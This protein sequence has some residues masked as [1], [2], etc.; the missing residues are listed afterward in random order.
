MEDQINYPRFWQKEYNAT[1][2]GKFAKV[3]GLKIVGIIP[4]RGGSKGIPGKNLTE[5]CGRPLLSWSIGQALRSNCVNEVY[6]SSDSEEILEAAGRFGASPITRPA[7]LATDEASSEAAL[8]HALSHIEQQAGPPD[9]VLFLQCT[10][11]LRL[12]QDI[13]RAVQAL[14]RGNA[15]SLLSV[16]P[17]QGV[18]QWE[19]GSQGWASVNYDYRQR[20][21]RQDSRRLFQENGSIYLFKPHILQKH[22]NRLGGVITVLEMAPWQAHEIDEWED[23]ALCQH[24]MRRYG[25]DRLGAPFLGEVD[26]VAYDFDGVMTDNRVLVDEQGREY[27]FCNRG[28][29]WAVDA[30]RAKG[31][32]QL[33]ITSE[34][35]PVVQ[36]RAAKL[37]IGVLSSVK[38]KPEALREWCRGKGIDLG[39]VMFVGN[40]YNDLE[41]MR[42]IGF[43]VCP[44]D[45]VRAVKDIAG[46]VLGARGGFG[47]VR[48]V[49]E[50]LLGEKM[51]SGGQDP[52]TSSRE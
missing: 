28:D 12:P 21:R 41:V 11:P 2:K 52:E 29:G 5:F 6:V 20:P 46:W 33:I 19:K 9:L 16:S 3:H 31:L 49:A 51:T 23:V 39:R 1:Q 7:E 34:T 18:F 47:V 8:L 17:S 22:R 38:D 13:E 10:S 40:D 43:P 48:E 24:Y 37:S 15:D 4:A 50:L 35:N 32:E 44:S 26:L 14:L 25:L 27:V 36:K 30:L 42:S 45:A